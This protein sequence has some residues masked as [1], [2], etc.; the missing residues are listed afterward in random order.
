MAQFTVLGITPTMVADIIATHANARP[1]NQQTQLGPSMLGAACPRK[2]AHQHLGTPPVNTPDP[3]ASWIGTEAHAGME[4]AL[5]HNDQWDTEIPVALPAYNIQGTADAYHKPSRTV[6]DW[7]FTNPNRIKAVT[8]NGPGPQYRVQAHT[9]GLALDMA[10]TP[11]EHVAV[12]FIPRSGL[13]TG[14][15]VWTEP[16]NHQIVE[17][18]LRRWE[19]IQLVA[20]SDGPAAIPTADDYCNWCPWHTGEKDTDL[21]RSC[22]G[23]NTQEEERK[24]T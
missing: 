20:D 9:Y 2:L 3:L 4:K 23:H 14:I 21:G 16:L 24:R 12:V 13:S 22:P 19:A 6:V 17:D 18:A 8:K 10:G 15:H 5:R 7:K 11:V 1:R